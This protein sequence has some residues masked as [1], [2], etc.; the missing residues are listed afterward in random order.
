MSEIPR[1]LSSFASVAICA[2]RSNAVSNKR[3]SPNSDYERMSCHVDKVLHSLIY[4]FM[5]EDSKRS[6][7]STQLE[8][9]PYVMEHYTCW[10]NYFLNCTCFIERS[11]RP[12]L[13][14]IPQCNTEKGHCSDGNAHDHWNTRNITSGN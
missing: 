6:A 5:R 3:L 10:H 7:R 2:T 8:R 1:V 13:F 11:I 14:K 9:I 4:N 12:V